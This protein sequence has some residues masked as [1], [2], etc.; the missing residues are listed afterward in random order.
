MNTTS[1]NPT[2]DL[3][4]NVTDIEWQDDPKFKPDKSS[5]WTSPVEQDGWVHAHNALRGEIKDISLCLQSV[6]KKF[7]N[8]I[9]S[10][11]SESI[12]TMWSLH[13][14]HIIS[15]H[16]NEDKIMTPFMKKRIKLPD[17]LE[18]DHTIILTLID[19]VTA[20][21]NNLEELGSFHR[22]TSA[23]DS[24]A[25]A[26]LPHLLEEERISLPLLRAYFSPREVKPQVMKINK[27]ITDN[28]GGSFV[29]YMGEE[30]FRNG[31][32]KQEGIPFFVWHLFFKA[33]HN[34]FLKNMKAQF[35]ALQSGTPPAVEKSKFCGFF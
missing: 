3:A 27:R 8:D 14:E 7:P 28:E 33:K 9:P 18:S 5:T 35:D 24:Y 6:S 10:W 1:A 30:N 21:A 29:H 15:H 13:K 34:F 17:K 19:A 12:K 26:L 20:A 22:I 4:I 2:D 23:F 25:A 11:T 16:D 32:M 31:F